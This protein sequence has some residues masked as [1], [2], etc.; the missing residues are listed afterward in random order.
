MTFLLPPGIKGLT[1]FQVYFS[2]LFTNDAGGD[3]HQ[4]TLLK[5][6]TKFPDEIYMLLVVEHLEAVV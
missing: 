2:R 6:Q 3:L 4:L 1:G 5:H